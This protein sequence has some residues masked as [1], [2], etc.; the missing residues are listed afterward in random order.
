MTLYQKGDTFAMKEVVAYEGACF[1]IEWF[2]NELGESQA[3]EYFNGLNDVQKRKVLMLFKRMGDFGKIS[4]TTKF[5]NE[6][7]KIFAFKPQPD[8]FLSFFYVGK[9]IIVT[10]AF[11]K[12][13]QKIPEEEKLRA[14]FDM[15]NYNERV[16]KDSYYE[17]D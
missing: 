9:K 12:K 8:R 1:R 4:D 15:Q 17:K 3:L 6:G 14:L 7:D 13:S 16:L 11:R 5:R 2:Y 10:N